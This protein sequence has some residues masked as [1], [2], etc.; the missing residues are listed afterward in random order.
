[1]PDASTD[2]AKF[3]MITDRKGEFSARLL[4]TSPGIEQFTVTWREQ[5]A[6]TAELALANNPG[7]QQVSLKLPI[8][9]ISFQMVDISGKPLSGCSV[10]LTHQQTE[11]SIQLQET[12]KGAYISEELSDGTYEFSINREH[13]ESQQDTISVLGGES[14]QR[15]IRLYHYITVKGHVIDGKNEGISA[16]TITLRNARTATNKKII[17]GTDGAFE[18]RLLVKEIGKE[19]GE[20]TWLGKHGVYTKE[21]W[22]D[23]PPQ[24]EELTLPQQLTRLPVN[25]IS[26]EVKSV[27]AT[28]IAGARVR[29]THQKS[30]QVIEA[31]DNG[32]GNYEG[33]ELPDGTY[34]ILISKN[35]YL[36]FKLENITVGSGEHKSDLLVSTLFHY[37]TMSGVV[38]NGKHQGGRVP[39]GSH[40]PA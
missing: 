4:V 38:L 10:T 22:L 7:T 14:K 11:N 18:M 9:F 3:E 34:D 32:N 13:Y 33:V 27:A 35:Q 1:M 24:P 37:I 8:N 39:G 12:Q 16:A 21:F 29:L 15:S 6:S 30:Q 17:S 19:Q 23:L 40:R 28:G 36:D 26:L 25:Y 20:I 31:R 5:Y 2:T